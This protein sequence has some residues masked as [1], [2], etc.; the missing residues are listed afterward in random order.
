MCSKHSASHPRVFQIFR[1]Y[2]WPDGAGHGAPFA[3]QPRRVAGQRAVRINLLVPMQ[4]GA[5]V[6]PRLA[7]RARRRLGIYLAYACE[8]R[9]AKASIQRC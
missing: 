6:G 7:S 5:A 1:D 3:Q 9:F 2:V 8:T 4:T